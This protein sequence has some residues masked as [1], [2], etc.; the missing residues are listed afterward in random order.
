MDQLIKYPTEKEMEL[1]R[2]IQ[3]LQD[4]LRVAYQDK[5]SLQEALVESNKQGT[6]THVISAHML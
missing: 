2:Y 5:V 3:L 6:L 4:K 1:Q